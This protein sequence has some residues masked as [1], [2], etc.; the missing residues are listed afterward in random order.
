M[1][2]NLLA[3]VSIVN[4][5]GHLILDRHVRPREKVTDFRTAVSGIRP[6]DILGKD[7]KDFD[8]VQKECAEV[9]KDRI[10]VG[11]ALVNDFQ[12][13]LLDH[14]RKL[15]RDTSTYPPYRQVTSG[16]T[17]SMRTLAKRFLGM[18]I[19]KGEHSSVSDFSSSSQSHRTE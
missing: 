2:R 10:V 5:H 4:F 9:F 14:P 18:Q 1:P 13:L 6:A 15:I 11:H 8:E 16:T 17:P 7:A 19:Q 12:A 3:R